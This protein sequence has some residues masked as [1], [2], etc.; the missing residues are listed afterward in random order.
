[1]RKEA[2]QEMDNNRPQLQ[3]MWGAALVAAGI[4]VFYKI[5]QKIPEILAAF[6][7]LASIKYFVYFSFYLIGVMLIGGGLAKIFK[8]IKKR[9]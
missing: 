8:N 6:D 2:K 1:M 7:Q 3:L 4:G 5:P 9:F